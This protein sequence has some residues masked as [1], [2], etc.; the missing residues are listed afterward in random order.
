LIVPDW[1]T[2]PELVF[3]A[4]LSVEVDPVRTA[5]IVQ[6]DAASTQTDPVEA[7]IWVE[8]AWPNEEYARKGAA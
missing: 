1:E 8:E 7:D 4:H 6:V 2:V 3:T 5:G